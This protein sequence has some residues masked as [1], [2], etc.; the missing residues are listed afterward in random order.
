MERVFAVLAGVSGFLGVALGA[1]GA[2]G[3]R[4]VFARSDDPARRL[5]WW[6]TAT[7]YHLVH[8]VALGLAAWLAGRAS[9]AGTAPT[10]AGLSFAAGTVVFSGSLYVM[11][12]TGLRWLGAVT[13]IGGVLFLVG[14]GALAYA[15]LR[16]R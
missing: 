3:L 16:L 10:V 6:E 15:G 12:V 4:D 5:A 13:P 9:E 8:A 14:W 2:H 11:A 1:F 7:Q